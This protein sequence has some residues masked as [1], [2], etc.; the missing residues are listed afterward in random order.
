MKT[1]AKEIILN[2]IYL[3]LIQGLNY[4]LP[5]LTLP[6]LLN[7]LSVDSFGEYSFAFAFSQFVILFV[8]FG[9]NISATKTIAENRDNRI[10]VRDLFIKIVSIKV[11]FLIIS[12]VFVAP[13]FLINDKV[14]PYAEAIYL[15]Y[16]MVIGTVIFP[17][18]WFQGLNK[19]KV[20]SVINAVSKLCTYPFLFLFVK[21]EN[22]S[23][24]T[25]F[26][27]SSA[28]LLA[29]IISMVYV[30][31]KNP[32][33]YNSN[34]VFKIKEYKTEIKEGWPIFLSN[35]SISLYT[36]SLTI[37]LGFFSTNFYVGLFGA[38]ERIV[39]VVC[40]GILGP[41]NQACFPVIIR[42]KLYDF[43]KAKVMVKYIFCFVL[44]VLSF[45]YLLYFLLGELLIDHFLKSYSNIE[46]QLTIFMGMIF[47]IALGGILGQ[48]GLLG[49]G[50]EHHKK[51]FSNIYIYIGIFSI[52][53][54]I[55][56]IYF[57][58]ID[59]AMY[60]MWLVEFLIFITILYYVKKFKFL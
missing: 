30:Y 4:L 6:Y 23:L 59:G 2:S 51:V 48:L 42:T 33:Y 57:Y 3:Y 11:F 20:L 34:L 16:T 13:L 28:F 10:F 45:V 49:L 25:I 7:T 24:L 8:D 44:L 1:E 15:S 31:W 9:F 32:W 5:L 14:R 39:R 37:L 41:V 58:K 12:L 60:S 22:D 52:P 21:N 54:S 35:S 53:I 50:N 46:N 27:Q 19:M 47:P 29:G 36:N 56:M 38:M 26:I 55:L 18:W 43:N 17:I 40:F